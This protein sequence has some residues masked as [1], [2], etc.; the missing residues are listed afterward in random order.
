[1]LSH[2]GLVRVNTLRLEAGTVFMVRRWDEPTS[3]LA[4]NMGWTIAWNRQ[5]VTLLG[6]AA[7]GS[8]A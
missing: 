2:V 5:I 3:P 1:M 7:L 6:C 4:A 8:A